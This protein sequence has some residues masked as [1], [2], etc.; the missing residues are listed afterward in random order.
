MDY[1]CWWWVVIGRERDSPRENWEWKHRD[2][3]VKFVECDF[4]ECD[5]PESESDEELYTGWWC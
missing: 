1:E 5:P 3:E 2:S 4:V